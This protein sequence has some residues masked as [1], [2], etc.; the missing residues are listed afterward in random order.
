MWFWYIVSQKQLKNEMHT[1]NSCLTRPFYIFLALLI[2][3]LMNVN[4]WSIMSY[5]SIPPFELV[6]IRLR[7]INND[8]NREEYLERAL[9]NTNYVVKEL[10]KYKVVE[11]WKLLLAYVY[12]FCTIIIIRSWKVKYL[13]NVRKKLENFGN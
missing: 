1:A 4:T 10:W 2:F 8:V 3:F 9:E 5:V 7:L 11:R 13:D 6:K 12:K